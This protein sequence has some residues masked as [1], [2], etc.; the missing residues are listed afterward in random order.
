MGNLRSKIFGNTQ[1][2]AATPAPREPTA[3]DMLTLSVLGNKV[4]E[5]ASY[6]G[7]DVPKGELAKG[8]MSAQQIGS[9]KSR[10]DA[11]YEQDQQAA[12]LKAQQDAVAND[13]AV[14][15]AQAAAAQAEANAAAQA[16]ASRQ[17]GIDAANAQVNA[18]N[19]ATNGVAQ[20]AAAGGDSTA[21]ALDGGVSV[22]T[23]ANSQVSASYD[24][25]RRFINQAT[26]SSAASVSRGG[27]GISI[28]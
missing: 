6:L 1:S 15:A 28:S 8:I 23:N 5:W 10:Y 16:A 21:Q 22:D 14:K 18:V 4:K 3:A 13:P 26:A 11:K 27:S 20:R 19:A 25:R 17:A 24:P 9:I 7:E 2:D 12:A